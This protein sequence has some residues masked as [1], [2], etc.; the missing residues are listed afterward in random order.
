MGSICACSVF[1]FILSR[2]LPNFTF[3]P[4]KAVTG[5][6]CP[7]CG[8]IRTFNLLLQGDI[9]GALTTNPLSVLFLISILVSFVW[10]AIDIIKDSDSYTA[11]IKRPAPKPALLISLLILLLNWIWNIYKGL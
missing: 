7:G 10:L 5:Y 11:L 6:P 1:L 8:G 2:L 3:C 9:A 4:F